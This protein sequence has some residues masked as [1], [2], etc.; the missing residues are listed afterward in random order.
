[1]VDVIKVSGYLDPV[2]VDFI[3]TSLDLAEQERSV[4]LV[5]QLDSP[6]AV[7]TDRALDALVHRLE[8]TT[9]PIGVWVGPSGSAAEGGA[10]RLVDA[11]DYVG[12]S[13]GSAVELA[14]GVR[15]GADEALD[16]GVADFPAPTVGDFIVGLPGVETRQVDV[17][18]EPRLEPVTPVRFAGLTLLDQLFHTVAS[19]AIAYL[20]FVIGMALIL[21]EL[22]TAGVGVAGVTGAG[23]FV[24]GCYG[25]AVLPA[26]GIGVGLLLLAMFGY[27]VDVQTGVP[28]VWTGIA[29]VAIVLGSLLLYDGV[30]LSWITQLLAV[31]GI[32]VAMITGMP[33]M[34]RSRF[35]TPTIGREWMIGELGTAVSAVAPDG[36]VS[37]REAPWRAR[38]NRATPIDA[39]APIRVA[40]IEG[41]VLEVEP[42]EGAARDYREARP[43]RSRTT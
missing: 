11:A 22:Y 41:L 13:P 24:L 34:V 2:L 29:T 1:V 9:V 23:F 26:T 32:T 25:L 7:V 35:S 21:F 12:V 20:L 28:R 6:G 4:A 38:T 42:L 36:V 17:G 19:P 14:T 31:V 27:A 18:G 33:A 30:E 43:R 3:E 15:V 16:Q 5:L 39:G 10:G 8:E 40:A 37:V